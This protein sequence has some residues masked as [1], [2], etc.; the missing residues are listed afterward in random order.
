MHIAAMVFLRVD[1]L[2]SLHYCPLYCHSDFPMWLYY[3]LY[4][5]IWATI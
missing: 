2:V 1:I 3:I 4:M 5:K